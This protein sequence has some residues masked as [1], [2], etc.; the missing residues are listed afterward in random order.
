MKT[1]RTTIVVDENHRATTRL[2]DDVAPGTHDVIVI[3]DARQ[4]ARMR[5]IFSAHD[6]GSWPV[7]FTV[8]REDL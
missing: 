7:G 3:L 6:V 1:I 2:P 5:P 4:P 8:R